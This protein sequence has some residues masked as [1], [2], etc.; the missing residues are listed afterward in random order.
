MRRGRFAELYGERVEVV[1]Q[2]DD[3]AWRAWT[4][5][6]ELIVREDGP[7]GRAPAKKSP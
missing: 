4:L 7:V 6:R 2:G 5:Q 1:P 3:L